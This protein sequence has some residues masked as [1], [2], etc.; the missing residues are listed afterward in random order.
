[1]LNQDRLVVSETAGTTRDSIDTPLR[2]HGRTLVFVEKRVLGLMLIG[3]TIYQLKILQK[4]E[5]RR[6]EIN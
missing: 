2:Y 4:V 3:L 6:A 1:L 5:F